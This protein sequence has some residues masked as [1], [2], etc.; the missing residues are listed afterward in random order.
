MTLDELRSRYIELLGEEP[1]NAGVLDQI[2]SQLNMRLP[3]D[4]HN[5]ASFYSGGTV[6][7]ISHH[8]IAAEGPATN[9]VKE[10][11]RLREKAGIPHSMLV[12]AESPESLIVLATGHSNTQPAVIW[13]DSS[14]VSSLH[15]VGT[16]HNPQV[17]NSYAEFFE[18]LL[19][20]ETEER[21]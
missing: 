12:L 15:N 6:G 2:E 21:V 14:D 5:I 9:V 11:I 17:W 1:T 4:F 7:G 16:L 10:T 18:F 3:S 13:L 8:A 20:R 19:D